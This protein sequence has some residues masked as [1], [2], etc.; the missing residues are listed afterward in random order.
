MI[1]REGNLSQKLLSNSNV[2]ESI[3]YIVFIL[4]SMHGGAQ[5]YNIIPTNTTNNIGQIEREEDFILINFPQGELAKC[6]GQCDELIYL[7]SPGISGY[8]TDNLNMIDTSTFYLLSF[9]GFPHHGLVYQSL[10]GGNT[11]NTLLDT[12]DKLLTDLI[13]FDTV[14][15]VTRSNY[16]AMFSNDNG[17]SWNVG[18]NPLIY[19]TAH[20]KLNDSTAII[21]T[22]EHTS[23]STDR[24]QSWDGLGFT[25][26]APRAFHATHLDSMYAISTIS[27]GVYFSYRFGST[28][29]YWYENFIP[30]LD[31]YGIFA[32]N[33]HEVYVTGQSYSTGHARIMKTTDLGVNWSFYDLGFSGA[34]GDIEFLNDSI[35][36]IGGSNGLLIRWNS[37][38]HFE[39]LGEEHLSI[40]ETYLY[41]NPVQSEI[42]FSFGE[43]ENSE[44]FIYSLD[45][46]EILYQTI[47]DENSIDVSELSTGNY[48]IKVIS[49][50]SVFSGQF[51]KV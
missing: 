34:L 32:K 11:W 7:N 20:I 41:P 18:V 4:C 23:I 27:S 45:G 12:T 31:P 21:G 51:V 15:F 33:S 26:A 39:V 17:A 29:G 38:S 14:L 2:K 13:V 24:G 46:K 22:T 9:V 48:F 42:N 6:Y 1:L 50:S 37:N 28:P 44:I 36:L 30:D 16:G 35:A 3:S 8:I 47:S 40:R 5:G 49:E 19:P 43:I 25:Q 10:D